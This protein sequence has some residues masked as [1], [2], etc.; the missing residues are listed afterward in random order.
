MIDNFLVVFGLILLNGLFTL[1]EA[2]LS[3]SRKSRLENLAKKGSSGA[4]AALDLLAKS[5]RYVSTVQIGITIVGLAI[6]VFAG[7]G[8][9]SWL[10]YR[11]QDAGCAPIIAGYTS[12]LLIVSVVA[13]F[14]LVFGVMIPR[15]LGGQNP[16]R[17]AAWVAPVIKPVSQFARPFHWLTTQATDAVL[18]IFGIRNAHDDDQVTEEEVIDIIAQG[19]SSGTIE[20]VEQ[21]ML[22]R[23]LLL[24]DRSVA[25]LM[26]N[27]IEIE[28]LDIN[29]DLTENL[30]KIV[31]S[32]H[33]MFPVCDREI[34]KVVG[35][36]ASK[37]LL[38]HLQNSS[39]TSLQPLL[40]PLKVIPENMKAL[41]ALEDFKSNNTKMAVVVDEFGSVQGILTQSDLLESIIAEHDTPDEENQ[42]SIVQRDKNSY[43]VDALLPFE[44]FLQYFEIEDV[45]PSDKTGFHSLA[46]F[47]LHLSKQI[48][49]TGERFEWKNYR[50]EVVDMDGN[51]IDKLM[52]TIVEPESD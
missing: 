30:A 2:S 50:F 8:F 45:D 4:R 47:I 52:V 48:P 34:D 7:N 32:N 14:M 10:A 15:R 20:E 23:V 6:G 42:T 43:L 44:E 49:T 37:K 11:L 21:D 9:I 1:A 26:T 39:F 41:A 40:N 27:R 17:I 16:E 36:L 38:P 31:A 13:F 25:S 3:F 22:E 24:G 5:S 18:R 28:W 51:R 29:E 35:I 12:L 19:T 33:S 46:G